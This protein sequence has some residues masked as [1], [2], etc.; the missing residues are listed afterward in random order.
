MKAE[1][2]DGSD[3]SLVLASQEVRVNRS[4]TRGADN[5]YY[6]QWRQAR[7]SFTAKSPWTI[8]R[9]SDATSDYL[10]TSWT[11]G[12]VADVSMT[13]GLEL[14]VGDRK[15]ETARKGS[16]YV[17]PSVQVTNTGKRHVDRETVVVTA[18]EGM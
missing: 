18:P 5:S 14:S 15:P 9:F 7:Y 6:P 12:V 13:Y 10:S 8:I 3:E 17:Y 4:D 16:P 2:L 1:A 11:G